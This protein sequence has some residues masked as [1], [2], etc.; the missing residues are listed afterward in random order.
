MEY[1]KSNEYYDKQGM[2][3]ACACVGEGYG[4][5]MCPCQMAGA[6]L[7]K[8]VEHVK[9]Q[10]ESSKRLKKFFDEWDKLGVEYGK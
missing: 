2:W 5:P 4:E 9:A 3:S 10:E 7:P 8:S 1:N 6:G